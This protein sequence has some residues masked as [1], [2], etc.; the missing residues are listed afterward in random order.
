MKVSIIIPALNEEGYIQSA[1]E[2]ALRQDYPHVEVIVVDNGSTDRT[3]EIVQKYPNVKL[4]REPERGLLN[5]REAGRLAAKGDIIAQ[6]DADCVAPEHWVS[7]ALT[8]FADERVVA[9]SGPYDFYDAP[10]TFYKVIMPTQKYL[11]QPFSEVINVLLKRSTLIGGNAFIRA[12]ALS[13]IG[14]YNTSIK[15][16]GEDADTGNRL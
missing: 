9:V 13:D 10:P 1:I 8:Y 12:K 7:S 5:A 2:S 11:M 4:I 6:M 15:F 3:V 16:H 14:G